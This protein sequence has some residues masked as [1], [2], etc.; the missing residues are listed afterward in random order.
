[1]FKYLS[2]R[3]LLLK[4]VPSR[5]TFFLFALQCFRSDRCSWRRRIDTI[6]QSS[7]R[8]ARRRAVCRVGKIFLLCATEEVSL[9]IH[10][11]LCGAQQALVEH[12][13]WACVVVVVVL[14]FLFM[15]LGV[16]HNQK[17]TCPNNTKNNR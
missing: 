14:S 1:M 8:W 4:R 16:C 11:L 12:H 10:L 9:E 13:L 3:P 17:N 6:L 5:L 7:R 15:F 2:R